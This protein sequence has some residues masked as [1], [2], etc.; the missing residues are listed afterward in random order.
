[1]KWVVGFA[2]LCSLALAVLGIHE[3]VTMGT[4]GDSIGIGVTF[5][6]LNLIGLRTLHKGGRR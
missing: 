3:Q 1:M 5:L 2:A 6:V 4:G